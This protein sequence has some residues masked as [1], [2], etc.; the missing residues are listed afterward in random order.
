[1]LYFE[2]CLNVMAKTMVVAGKYLRIILSQNLA[3]FTCI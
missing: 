3:Q 1:L 2:N